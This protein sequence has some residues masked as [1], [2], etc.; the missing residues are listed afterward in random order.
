[1]SV[2]GKFSFACRRDFIVT[3]IAGLIPVVHFFFDNIDVGMLFYTIIVAFVAL[4]SCSVLNRVTWYI[5]V[6]MFLISPLAC[7]MFPTGDK[8]FVRLLIIITYVVLIVLYFNRDIR[9]SHRVYI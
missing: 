2:D 6:I 9:L 4:M 3:I 5:A 7:M 1:M 8:V